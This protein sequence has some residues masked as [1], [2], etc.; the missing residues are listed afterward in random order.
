[1]DR[2]MPGASVD[3]PDDLINQMGN[4]PKDRH[5]LAAAVVAEAGFIVTF[6]LGDFPADTCSPHDVAP[7]APDL[8]ASRLVGDNPVLVATAI[9]E[10]AS[11]RRRPPA[12]PDEIMTHL[13][14]SLPDTIRRLREN[15]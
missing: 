4:H 7:E 3:P 1:M 2:A 11:R 13:A 12:T 8:F 14:R 10:M 15:S 6:N 5:V 9:A